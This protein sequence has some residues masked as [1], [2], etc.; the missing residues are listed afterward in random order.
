MI[1]HPQTLA[2]CKQL[3]AELPSE[4]KAPALV[5][6][7]DELASVRDEILNMYN[8]HPEN[9]WAPHHFTWGMAVR[10]LLRQKGFGE[11][12]FGIDNMD[13]I[14][15]SLVEEALKLTAAE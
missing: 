3:Y 1:E 9:W 2:E 4:L 7:A 12:Y 10:N 6:L 15:I 8:F 11:E 5:M 13:D 14:Y